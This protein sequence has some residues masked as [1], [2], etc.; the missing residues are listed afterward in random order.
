[1]SIYSEQ[2][3]AE[4]LVTGIVALFSF[5]S[6][7]KPSTPWRDYAYRNMSRDAS[8]VSQR[9]AGVMNSAWRKTVE[10]RKEDLQQ[11]DNTQQ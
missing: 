10:E 9:A 5:G 8:N 3:F 6:L 7:G 11:I 2:G 1:M 4:R